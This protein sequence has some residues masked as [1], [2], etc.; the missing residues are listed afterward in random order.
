LR[1]SDL[2]SL[3]FK[4]K[5]YT[6]RVVLWSGESSEGL[7]KNAFSIFGQTSAGA[8]VFSAFDPGRADS[9]FCCPIAEIR[10]PLQ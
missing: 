4:Q 10:F 2:K 3:S 6:P 5:S 8:V 1:L 9:S 7:I